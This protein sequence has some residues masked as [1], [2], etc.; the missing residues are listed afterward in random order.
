MFQRHSFKTI[1]LAVFISFF[2]LSCDFVYHK[3]HK[4]GAE[5]KELVGVVEAYEKNPTVKEI[6][7]LLKLY[8]Y[9]PG[10]ADGVLGFKTREAVEKF[11]KDNNLKPS[12]FIDKPTWAKLNFFKDNGLIE[13]GRTDIFLI[14]RIL[15][16]SG[17]P[18][19][20][21]DGEMGP[22]T[23]QAIKNFQKAHGLKPDGKVGYKTLQQLAKYLPLE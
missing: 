8:G 11:Q 21:I 22:K 10:E 7:V 3:L 16:K 12:R 13:G 9:N 20:K 19:G 2:S 6:Q 18:T 5:E 15:K 1:S 17:F 14:Q 4:E 23:I